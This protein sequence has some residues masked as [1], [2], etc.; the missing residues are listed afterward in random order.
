MDRRKI[1]KTG[2]LSATALGAAGAMAQA[3]PTVSTRKY[4]WRMVTT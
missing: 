3:A 1:L 4:E 2:V